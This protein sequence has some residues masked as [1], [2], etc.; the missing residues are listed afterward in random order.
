MRKIKRITSVI[1]AALMIV[2]LFAAVPMTVNAAPPDSGSG[3]E[4]GGSTTVITPVIAADLPD[5]KYLTF[6]AVEDN[7][8]VTLKVASCDYLQYNKN[9]SGW[10]DYSVGSLIALAS[11]GDYVRFRGT[12]TKFNSSNH[13]SIDGKVACSGNVMSLRLDN[14]GEVQGLSSRCFCYMFSQCAG[15]TAAPELPETTLADY[16]YDRMFI[17]CTNLTAAPE[18]PATTLAPYCYNNMFSGCERLT[19]APEL[20]ATSLANYCYSY[21]FSGCRSLTTAPELPATSLAYNCYNSM[22]DG[23]ASLTTA[24][25]LPATSLANYCYYGMFNG[26]GRLTTAPELPA[27]SLAQNCYYNMFSG[28]TS[29][30][31]APGLPATS[32]AYN[33]YSSMFEDC[34]SLTTA[35]VLPATSLAYGC[36]NSMFSGCTSLTTAPELPATELASHC[37]DSMFMGCTSLT[38]PPELP[39]T[40]L[41]PY[42]YNTM[43]SGCSSIKLSETQTAEYS[44]P[45][46][47]PS[48]GNGTT[49]SS[50]LD[51][52]FAGTGGTFTGTPEINKTYYRPAKKYTVTWKNGDTVLKTDKNV[53]EGT[54]PEYD[55]A[56]PTK[57]ADENY[58]YTFA[59]WTPEVVAA[60]ADAEYTAT[61]TAVPKGIN[62]G[63]DNYIKPD[64]TIAVS[65][66]DEGK[67]KFGLSLDSYL[68]MQMLGIQ[69][70]SAIATQGG[71]DGVRFVT[72]V[73][74]NLLKGDNI[75]DY[76]YIVAKFNANV[77]DLN[78][79]MDK[80]TAEKFI[81]QGA[82]DTNIFSCK[83]SSNSISG[84]FGKFSSDTDYKYVTLSVTG[85]NGKSGN[86]VARF[87]VQ[88]KD[89]Q[90]HYADY[91]K[92]SNQTYSGMAFDLNAVSANLG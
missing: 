58:T 67:T 75:K 48:G 74:S 87:Y 34:E 42:C 59:G 89:G 30:T 45:Y 40:A 90:Y 46:S 33:C 38:T 37:Y 13:V 72:V 77:E 91:I 7:S 60:N 82:A 12:G 49:A 39:A 10:V 14:Y 78:T 21:M 17:G 26:C 25:A 41:A 20:P 63:G 50:A 36:Y 43:F 24:P 6:T 71:D 15:L 55:G 53:S 23:C 57:D 92:G 68:N 19:T 4:I 76:G 51:N 61:F 8:S 16:C 62:Y 31:T 47:V 35:P 64:D 29:L 83:G 28:C 1:L 81:D 69:L 2:S 22:F 65:N 70:K 32:L 27:T 80:F 84:E 5:S 73:N 88:T 11:V 54:T 18:L 79:N 52:M 56:T 9:N 85:T 66:S 44:I 3:P 86:L